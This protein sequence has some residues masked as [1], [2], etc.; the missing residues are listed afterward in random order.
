MKKMLLQS[1]LAAVA[2]S[3]LACNQPQMTEDETVVGEASSALSVAEESGD[4][5]ADVAGGETELSLTADADDSAVLPAE[6][7]SDA[8]GVC[9]L[10]GRKA[11]VLARYDAN[12]NGQLDRPE[13][14]ALRADLID[15]G[16]FA[17]RFAIA[18]RRHVLRRLAWVFDDNG[19]GQLSADERTALIDALQ[20][21]CE[22]IKAN[23]I[24]RFDANGDGSLDQTERQA[25]KDALRARLE[26]ERQRILTAYDVN[27]NGVLDEG[28]RLQLRSDRIAAFRT[29][30]A[31]VVAHFDANGDGSLDDAEKLAL[32]QAIQQRIIEGRDAE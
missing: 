8:D 15:R 7:A 14:A 21:R 18:H 19:D 13:L 31:E 29:R 30:K 22:R 3:G 32:R 27:Q 28:E 12:G 1:L 20:A 2:F 11:R 26:Q 23:V 5:T 6:M 24:A 10:Q 16:G 9:D 17:A 25:A 4:V